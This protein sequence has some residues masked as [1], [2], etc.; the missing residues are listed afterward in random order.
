[1]LV[2]SPRSG[3][4]WIGSLFDSHPDT[5]Y[6][7]EPDVIV[8]EPRLPMVPSAKRPEPP[9]AVTRAFLARMAKTRA[10]RSV[11][12][13]ERFTKAWRGTLANRVRD[14]MILAARGLAAALPPLRLDRRISIPDLGGRAA[15]IVVLKSVDA[16]TRLSAYARAAPEVTFLFIIRHPCGVVRSKQRGVAMGKMAEEPLYD[17]LF[18]LPRTDGVDPAAARQWPNERRAAFDWTVRNSWVLDEVA[19]LP[20]VHIVDYEKVANDPRAETARLF[21]L[22]GL[23]ANAQTDAYLDSLL[24][25]ERGQGDYFAIG[26]NPAK[27]A[28]EWRAGLPEADKALVAETVAGS[29]AGALFGY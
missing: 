5:L 14:G 20:N 18:A 8:K 2:G 1:M 11:F 24:A 9:A 12:M 3:T 27:A 4:T 16:I 17:D 10:L 15:P 21:G 28:N 26:R 29:P 7:H 25:T 6:L 19:G 23:P 13:R 22:T